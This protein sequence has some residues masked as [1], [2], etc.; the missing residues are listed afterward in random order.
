MISKSAMIFMLAALA[1]P[2]P[3]RAQDHG[4]TIAVPTVS[5][6]G[7][8]AE[9]ARPDVAIAVLNVTDDRPTAN[10][11][12]NENARLS[13]AVIDG[14]KGSG[15]DAKDIATLGLSLSPIM[16]EER[17][18]KTNPIVKR[19]VTGFRASNTLSVRIRA[20]ERAGALVATSVQNGATYQGVSF[21]LSDREAREDALRVKAVVNAMHRAS[22]Y[23]QGA[24]M[25]LGAL[26]SISADGAEA[27]L[28]PMSGAVR[29]MA[30]PQAGANAPVAIEPG[31]I[32]LTETA[33]ATWELTPP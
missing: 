1:G 27:P 3:A 14:L 25:K 19:T 9:D 26:Q 22:L 2:I 6:V 23:A 28:R 12:A 33:S 29:A 13:T 10:D 20:I 8:A 30:L 17:D 11:A 21:D 24:S 31:L 5:V 4:P 16:S 7:V 18:A 15:V 32:T